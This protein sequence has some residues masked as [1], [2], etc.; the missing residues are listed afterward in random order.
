VV[1]SLI[2]NGIELENASSY[3]IRYLVKLIKG[4]AI[5]IENLGN[6]GYGIHSENV[7]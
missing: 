4:A 7:M 1:S 6:Y 2:F 3:K 5:S